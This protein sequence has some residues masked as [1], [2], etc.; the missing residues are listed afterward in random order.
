VEAVCGST[1]LLSKLA[2]PPDLQ[3]LRIVLVRSRNPLNIGAA[4][5]A[6]SNFGA[7][8]LRVV[9]PYEKAFREAI[10]AVGA[11][12]LL[13]KAEEH[14]SVEDATRDCSL[15]VGTTAIG[16][17]ELQ[18]ELYSLEEAAKK[19]HATLAAGRVA[20]LF[21]SE[22]T[23]LSN[24][25]LS[26]CHFLLRIPT[27]EE[28]RSMNLAQAVA[29]V[30]YE[31]SRGVVAVPK[32]K[33]KLSSGAADMESINRIAETLLETLHVSGYVNKRSAR[34]AE[35]KLRRLLRRF[36]L[37]SADAEVLLGMVRKILWKLK[38]E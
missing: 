23:G 7:F 8:H 12:P 25:D 34:T 10:S 38:S 22:K 28:H 15:V 33:N 9:T 4:A 30:V 32:P 14:G 29:I 17:R 11:A 6:M 27:R 16:H 18:H 19:I 13:A 37:S 35:E 20:I 31:L 5:R 24:Q 36:K 1:T 3:D 2:N 21:G 26:H